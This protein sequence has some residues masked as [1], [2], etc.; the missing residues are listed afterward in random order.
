MG[1]SEDTLNALMALGPDVWSSLRKQQTALL[2]VEAEAHVQER[3]S[4]QDHRRFSRS[5]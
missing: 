5:A 4:R 2:N 3:V 1:C